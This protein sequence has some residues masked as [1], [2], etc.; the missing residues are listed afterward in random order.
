MLFGH[1]T[2][3]HLSVV[4][5]VTRPAWPCR[6]MGWAGTEQGR[7]HRQQA[8]KPEQL[9]RVRSDLVYG[10]LANGK[11]GFIEHDN[12]PF[13][14]GENRASPNRGRSLVTASLEPA[15]TF[16]SVRT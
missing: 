7:N 5:G 8:H 14:C 11:A 12:L 10:P 4:T 9:E 15:S 3:P 13:E 1:T 16:P 6:I 2:P